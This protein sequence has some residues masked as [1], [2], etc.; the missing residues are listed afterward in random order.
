MS[1]NSEMI[2]V[3]PG[4]YTRWC[5]ET[6][7]PTLST[8]WEITNRNSLWSI[9]VK[10]GPTQVISQ[11]EFCVGC[12]LSACGPS[13]SVNGKVWKQ[14]QYSEQTISAGSSFNCA[15]GQAVAIKSNAGNGYLRSTFELSVLS[16]TDLL[17]NDSPSALDALHH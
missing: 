8:A 10:C 1:S 14:Y 16:E 17:G 7:A 2:S 13:A 11:G 12:S 4:E 5:M 9:T 3:E 6:A 15:A